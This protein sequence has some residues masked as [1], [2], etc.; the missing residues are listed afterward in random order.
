[1]EQ[2]RQAVAGRTA[3][4]LTDAELVRRFVDTRDEAAFELLVWRQGRMVRGVCRRVLRHEHDVEDAFQA[5]FLVLARKASSLGRRQALG[6]WL[7]RVAYRIALRARSEA[8]RRESRHREAAARRAPPGAA[9]PSADEPPGD[10]RAAVAEE[11]DRL[12]EKYRTPVVL[13][14]LEG[15]TNAEAARRM[16]CP[17]GTVVTRLARARRRLRNRLARRGLTAAGSALAA[18]LALPP[19]APGSPPGTARAAALF[20]TGPPG[21]VPVSGRVLLLTTR[22]LRSLLPARL[23]IAAA[24]FLCLA[25]AGAM[26]GVL[27]R[28]TP[29]AG[30]AAAADVGRDDETAS[31][32]AAGGPAR[33]GEGDAVARSFAT[34]ASPEVTVDLLNGDIK[35]VA[36]AKATVDTRVVRRSLSG[37]PAGDRD[38][39]PDVE[40]T[41]V[42]EGNAVRIRSRRLRGEGLNDWETPAEVRVPPGAAL[43]LRTWNG[44]VTLTGGTGAVSVQAANGAVRVKGAG[45]ALTLS[46]VNG[47]VEVTGA[48][49]RVEARTVNGR[50]DVDGAGAVVCASSVNGAIRFRGEPGAGPHR[51]TTNADIVLVLR[52]ETRFAI[53]AAT[54]CG[55]V[56]SDLPLR[57]P[58]GREARASFRLRT[59]YGRIAIRKG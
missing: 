24:G 33:P 21:A 44:S 17:V 14:Y 59:G 29:G 18:T 9:G 57:P 10:V 1:M 7:Y 25:L 28:R 20:A 37:V 47:S 38:G 16:G 35:V 13:C 40:V 49:G 3:E 46:T 55:T 4:G 39:R 54:W 23:K 11:V 8:I 50:I 12:P 31:P 5:T 15:K 6:G 30:S 19:G 51:F 41:A 52:G 48:T 45:G 53:D 43:T 2:L 27:A 22:A 56:E 26:P 36:D 42:Q 58:P 32:G 34:G